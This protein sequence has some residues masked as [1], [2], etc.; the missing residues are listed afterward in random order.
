MS[1][2]ITTET[3]ITDRDMAIEALE[4]ADISYTVQGDS[5]FMSSGDFRNARLDLKTGAISGDSDY[6]HTSEKFGLLRQH[7]GEAMVRA[8]ARSNGTTIESRD[9][10]EEGNIVLM[11]QVG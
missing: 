2:R 3:N 5:I 10:D 11:W 6:G 9:V 1:R 7:Y 4:L 8:E